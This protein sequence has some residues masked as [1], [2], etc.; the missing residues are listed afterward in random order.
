MFKTS[1]E[2]RSQGC[3][4][5][6][7]VHGNGGPWWPDMMLQPSYLGEMVAGSWRGPGALVWRA[8][9]IR[10][11]AGLLRPAGVLVHWS[12]CRFGHDIVRGRTAARS[13]GNRELWR[14]AP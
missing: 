6:N 3:I 1:L 2:P 14:L 9:Q 10:T 12:A 7:V 8:R 5:M 13:L 4:S 11:R